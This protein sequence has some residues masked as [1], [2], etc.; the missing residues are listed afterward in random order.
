MINKS[1]YLVAILYHYQLDKERD[2]KK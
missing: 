1:I 2:Q